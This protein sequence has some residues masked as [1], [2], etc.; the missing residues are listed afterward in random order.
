M[1][2]LAASLVTPGPYVA[3][4]GGEVGATATSFSHEG[5]MQLLCIIIH[6]MKCKMYVA[7]HVLLNRK[8]VVL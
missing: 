8:E 6:K 2:W 4:T 7:A 1:L 5:R 3:S